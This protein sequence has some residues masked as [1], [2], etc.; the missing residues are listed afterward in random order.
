MTE[1]GGDAPPALTPA[2]VSGAVFVRFNLIA[3][4]VGL[5]A[6]AVGA[7]VV[8]QQHRATSTQVLPAEEKR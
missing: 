7:Y 4:L 8:S 2:Q 3:L 5:I 6:L 1:P